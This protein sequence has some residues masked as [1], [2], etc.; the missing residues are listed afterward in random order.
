MAWSQ[1]PVANKQ[2]RGVM[3]LRGVLLL[4]TGILVLALLVASR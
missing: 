2:Q 3:S 4:F 1:P